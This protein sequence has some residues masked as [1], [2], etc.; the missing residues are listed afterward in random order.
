MKVGFGCDHTGIE[1]KQALMEHMTQKGYE[2]VDYGAYDAAG[3]KVDYPVPGEKVA[4][5]IRAGLE[6]VNEVG[7]E[8]SDSEDPIVSSQPAKQIFFFFAQNL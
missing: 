3:G 7:Q 2:C 6:A 1:L 8:L 5:A 4:A